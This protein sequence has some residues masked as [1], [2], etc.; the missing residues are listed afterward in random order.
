MILLNQN[1]VK[2]M[3][4]RERVKGLHT[5]LLTVYENKIVGD[6]VECGIYLGGNVIIAKKFFDSIGITDKNFYAYDT[7]SGMTAPGENDPRKAHI[8]WK[9]EYSCIG[10]LETVIEEFKYHQVLDEKI[11]IVQGDV[12][13]TLRNPINLPEKI[14]ILRLDTDWYESTKIELEILYERLSFGGFLIIDDYG[15]WSGCKKAVDDFFGHEFVEENFV[16]LDY[17]GIMLQ[18]H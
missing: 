2:T 6:F 1:E 15:H 14:S 18:K 5:A 17:T 4:S 13:T 11:I 8:H 7:F 9:D 3:T 12:C 16:K 10:T